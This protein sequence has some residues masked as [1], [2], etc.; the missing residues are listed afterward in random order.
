MRCSGFTDLAIVACPGGE[1]FA[2]E[3]IKHLTRVCE[4]KFHQ[5]M[6][7]LTDRYGLDSGSVIRDANFYRDLFSTELC[8]HDD[9][10][11][12]NP[13]HFKVDA[14][15][16]CFLNGELKTQIN[17]CIRGK[18][19]FIF[20]DVENHQP[21]LVNNG[22]SKKIFSV[23]DHVMM[24]IVTIDA[25]RHAGAGRVTLVLPTYPYSRQHK[26]C[27]REGLTAGLLGSVYEY[28][29]VSHIVTLD[30]HSREIENA[31]HRTRLENLHA[32]YQIIRELAKIENLSDPDIPFVVVAPDSGAVERNKFY[33][34]GLKKPLAMIYKVRDYSVVAQNAK[35]SNIVEI[36]L[37]G[38]VEG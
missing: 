15:F 35:Q 20:Q 30:L 32:S 28:L 26:K 36:N 23:N 22:K 6:D 7:R 24:L 29:G 38:D 13:P 37:L 34:S 33:S 8:A 19:V 14:Q 4:R 21:V 3:T 9:V 16:I 12:F 25:V 10:R 2:D 18:D 5:R 27:G 31:F 1:H 11:R 17:E